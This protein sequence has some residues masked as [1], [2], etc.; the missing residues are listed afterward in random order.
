M[1]RVNGRKEVKNHRETTTLLCIL[2]MEKEMS[3]V[4]KIIT[5]NETI[6]INL[7][8]KCNKVNDISLIIL[9]MSK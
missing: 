2:I 9:S 4:K 8:V 5:T 7:Y 1:N 6:S 3:S